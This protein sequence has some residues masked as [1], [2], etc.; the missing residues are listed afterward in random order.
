M[1][2]K[3]DNAAPEF[4]VAA[5]KNQ[6]Q[7]LQ[8]LL[9]AKKTECERTRRDRDRWKSIAEAE[10]SLWMR[11][12]EVLS[13]AEEKGFDQLQA[14]L[15]EARK[16]IARQRAARNIRRE[17]INTAVK[18]MAAARQEKRDLEEVVAQLKGVVA[19]LESQREVLATQAQDTIEQRDATLNRL[20]VWCAQW[21]RGD[22]GSVETLAGVVAILNLNLTLD[23]SVMD[24]R[25][26]VHLKETEG[27]MIE[28]AGQ[29]GEIIE[30]VGDAGIQ[31]TDDPL[32][33]V[34]DLVKA[35]Q[36]LKEETEGRQ[37]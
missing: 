26:A 7:T 31:L 17:L 1:T 34:K 23:A 10:H 20:K 30:V 27:L 8:G 6:V 3:D 9:H 36:E 15:L 24:R 2:K 25:R 13:V 33:M 16:V 12:A 28:A 4:R 21:V 11:A 37:I 19:D 32:K 22:I 18:K 35:Y 5:L 14:E 29:L